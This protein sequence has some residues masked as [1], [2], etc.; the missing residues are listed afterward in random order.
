MASLRSSGPEK[1]ETLVS[2]KEIAAFLDRAERTVKRWE[3][4]RGLPVHRV[5]GGERGGV[6]AFPEE[7]KA[8]LLGEQGKAAES[9][10]P[11]DPEKP[12]ESKQLENGADLLPALESE[13]GALRSSF[14]AASKKESADYRRLLAWMVASA[15]ILGL[16]VVAFLTASHSSR[17]ASLKERHARAS[18]HIPKPGAEALYLQ[19]R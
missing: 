6:F 9:A 3:R 16:A 4:E 8:W 10:S 11:V 7:L 14:Q 17:A 18:I 1:S 15:A 12:P 13:T 19:G 5:P 2:W